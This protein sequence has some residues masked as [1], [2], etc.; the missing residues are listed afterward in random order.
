M[1]LQSHKLGFRPLHMALLALTS[2][3]IPLSA[4]AQEVNLEA[5]TARRVGGGT[6]SRSESGA[7]GGKILD[8]GGAR[9]FGEWRVTVPEAGRYN[10]TIKYRNGDSASRPMTI[11]VNG[12]RLAPPGGA[13]GASHEFPSTGAWSR[14][15]RVV[16]SAQ[17]NKGANT[18]RMTAVRNGPDLD[19][20][21]FSAGRTP[22]TPTVT[23][24]PT[25]PARPTIQVP[26]PQPTAPPNQGNHEH[27]IELDEN[28][29]Y[30]VTKGTS[31]F[32]RFG[33]SA[34]N[35]HENKLRLFCHVSHFAYTDPIVFPGK[36][37]A[38][39]L[40]MFFGNTSTNESST[41]QSLMSADASTCKGG[42][43]NKSAYWVPAMHNARGE[44][45]I[46]QQVLVYY[47]ISDQHRGNIK[48]IPDG[49]RLLTGNPK[50]T[51]DSPQ[52]H[53]NYALNF[54]T[55]FGAQCSWGSG[56]GVR[57]PETCRNN[58][59]GAAVSMWI[60]FPSCLAVDG[61]GNPVLD[62]PDHSSHA[63]HI[64]Y[65]SRCPSSH[66]Y[67]IPQ[68]EVIVT[69]GVTD[70]TGQPGQWYL[71]SD[72]YDHQSR[73]GGYSLHA[74]WMEAWDGASKKSLVDNLNRGN[75][76]SASDGTTDG[77]K[78]YHTGASVY[79]DEWASYSLNSYSSVLTK[80][81]GLSRSSS[82]LSLPSMLNHSMG[83][84]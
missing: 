31:A 63:R 3:L 48:P 67:Q 43:L 42:T 20:I 81:P 40:H 26:T 73:G 25:A 82:G 23:P 33:T 62:S 74:D 51:A 15:G 16:V 65:N 50:A 77:R 29:T 57:L 37:A 52:N 70:Q 78:E 61:Q 10:V 59:E 45:I 4:L 39:H 30:R 69:Y 75:Y 6:K 49:V 76:L 13:A 1:F 12:A 54:L 84:K 28:F 9:S 5:E 44:A 47:K 80:E 53:N 46:P 2:S 24:T 83:H 19:L 35:D 32:G 14:W 27:S 68:V 36:K 21:T 8:F 66:P 11:S 34:S 22:P 64:H 56:S 7:S 18:I 38:T 79:K 72:M 60:R 17:L 71:S 58:G 41:R 55:A